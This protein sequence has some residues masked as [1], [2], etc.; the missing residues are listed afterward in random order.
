MIYHLSDFC[1]YGQIN[2]SSLFSCLQELSYERTMRVPYTIPTIDIDPNARLF[3]LDS[4]SNLVMSLADAIA[5]RR[6]KI[7]EQRITL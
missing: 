2:D 4:R 7:L 3:L 5:I 6:E 1:E